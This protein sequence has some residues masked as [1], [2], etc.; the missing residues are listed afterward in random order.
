MTPPI[1]WRVK[2][3]LDCDGII[4]GC[5]QNIEWLLPFWYDH[6]K[7][8]NDLPITFINYGM[9]RKALNWCQERGEVQNLSISDFFFNN[10]VLEKK[11]SRIHENLSAVDK[12]ILR[13]IRLA[14]FKKPFAL[15]LTPYLRTIWLDLDCQVRGNLS[16]LFSFAENPSEIAL[17]YSTEEKHKLRIEKG[18]LKPGEQGYNSGVIV[19]KRGST[20]INSWANQT[21]FDERD[22]LGDQDILSCL[23]NDQNIKI[24]ILPKLYNWRVSTWGINPKALI[25]HWSGA[26]KDLLYHEIKKHPNLSIFLV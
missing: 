18:F 1:D 5:N 4:A 10:R 20:L 16:T 7:K 12:E 22:L 2:G 25:L 6:I 14:W 21:I 17:A 11:E 13:K 15:L 3:L 8:H 26:A 24:S 23:I 19:Y 9:S